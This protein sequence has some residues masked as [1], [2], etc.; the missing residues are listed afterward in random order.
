VHIGFAGKRDIV[1]SLAATPQLGEKFEAEIQQH[2]EAVLAALPGRAGL[3]ETAFLCG[4]SQVA[5]GGDLLFARSCARLD[6]PQRIFLPQHRD[7]YLTAIGSNGLPDFSPAERAAAERALSGPTVVEE[8]VVAVALN[9]ADRFHETNLEIVRS[10]DILIGLYGA[11]AE[12]KMGGTLELLELAQ[13]RGKPS[14][15][16]EVSL[17][18]DSIQVADTWERF[19]S[20]LSKRLALPEE[21]REVRV[22]RSILEIDS[23]CA[24]VRRAA[25]QQANGLRKLF[26]AEALTIIG[27]HI[28]ATILATLV[29]IAAHSEGEHNQPWVTGLLLG[30]L[31]LLACGLAVHQHLHHSSMVKRWARAR[32]ISEIT[33]STQSLASIPINLDHLLS[34]DVPAQLLPLLRTL[35]VLHLKSAKY[36]GNA[37]WKISRDEYVKRRLLDQLAYYRNAVD[38][39]AGLVRWLP[40]L[41]LVCSIIAILATSSK[42]AIMV[43]IL[44]VHHGATNLLGAVAVAFPVLAVGFLS[45]AASLD[46]EARI[47]TY[48]ELLLVLEARVDQLRRTN[49]ERDFQRLLIET[50]LRLLGETATWSS[51]R[52]FTGVI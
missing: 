13:N 24:E 26:R 16:L 44:G 50:E 35:N 7:E 15:R 1:S 22:P 42:L 3:G 46:L 8:R 52:S 41:F 25:S 34:L 38:A 23:Y 51:R 47:Q 39:A 5:V 6:I 33:R 27:T 17:C 31:I 29:L 4:V 21:V 28:L 30:E 48:K 12:S 49:S 45:L 40:R 37:P 10:S 20:G 2:I 9:R 32:L 14:I 18:D 36:R 43:G 11:G 19:D